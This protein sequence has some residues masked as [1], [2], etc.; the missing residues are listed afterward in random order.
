[1]KKKSEI[2][3]WGYYGFKNLGDDV[4]LD[5]CLQAIKRSR[6]YENINVFGNYD[7]D[8]IEDGV[9]FKPLAGLKNKLRFLCALMRSEKLVWGGGT[10]FYKDENTGYSGLILLFIVTLFCF[11]TGT[12]N[13]FVGVGIGHLTTNWAKIIVNLILQFST[14]VVFRDNKSYQKAMHDFRLKKC[15]LGGDL[16]LLNGIYA[17]SDQSHENESFISVSGHYAYVYDEKLIHNYT[18]AINNVIERTGISNICFV[19]MH[20]HAINNDHEFHRELCKHLPDTIKFHFC[21]ENESVQKI[22]LSKY[23]IGMRLHSIVFA[24]LYKVPLVA[25]T[26]SPKI[27]AF[28][29]HMYFSPCVFDGSSLVDNLE[30]EQM[31]CTNLN[32]TNITDEKQ[33]ALKTLTDVVTG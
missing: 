26:Y 8:K 13:Y 6:R 18:V 5:V 7:K 12:K 21:N 28:L 1:M 23:H 31:T 17:N 27:N 14:F 11:I 19:S 32:I 22:A 30:L 25:F 33:R 24:T 9:T 10:C 29:E 4:M 2:T 20:Q 15:E 16:V 3:L